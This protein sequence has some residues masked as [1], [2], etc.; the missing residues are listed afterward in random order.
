MGT[1]L[2]RD[3]KTAK[4]RVRTKAGDDTKSYLIELE[5][6]ARLPLQEGGPA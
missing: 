3:G 5:A 6:D 1:V 4:V 2:S